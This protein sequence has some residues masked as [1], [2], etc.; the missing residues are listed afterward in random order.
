MTDAGKELVD[1]CRKYWLETG[2][3]RTAV[4]NMG[5]ELESHLLEASADNRDPESVIGEDLPGFAAAWAAELSPRRH[6]EMPSWTAV[7]QKLDLRSS[8]RILA[9]ISGAVAVALVAAIILT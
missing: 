3:S 5:K 9:W 8:S 6:R 2:L 1:R 7:E 4:D